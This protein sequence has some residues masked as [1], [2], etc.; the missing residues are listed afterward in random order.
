MET[1]TTP[2]KINFQLGKSEN[3]T[4]IKFSIKA[5]KAIKDRFLSDWKQRSKLHTVRR[6]LKQARGNDRHLTEE[7]NESKVHHM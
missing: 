1:T 5:L 2:E 4:K 7:S 6:Y 3:R